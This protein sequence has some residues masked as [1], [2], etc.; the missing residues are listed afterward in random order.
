[1][2]FTDFRHDGFFNIFGIILALATDVFFIEF[3]KD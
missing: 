3:R 1:M 2:M